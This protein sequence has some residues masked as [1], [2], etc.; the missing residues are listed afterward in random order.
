MC[1]SPQTD[2]GP[3]NVLFSETW[4]HDLGGGR[5]GFAIEVVATRDIK[6]VQCTPRAHP[7]LFIEAS[8]CNETCFCCETQDEELSVDYGPI[9]WR[10]NPDVPEGT[11]TW[12]NSSRAKP[13]K[14]QT[15][16]NQPMELVDNNPSMN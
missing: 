3:A 16:P 5:S 2:S 12:L 9:F 13:L 15:H 7:H 11:H 14:S 1:A 4:T 10:A 6:K 8:H